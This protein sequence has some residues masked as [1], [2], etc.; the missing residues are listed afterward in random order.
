MTVGADGSQVDSCRKDRV[1][2]L[3]FFLI[4]GSSVWQL[5]HRIVFTYKVML[6]FYS[7][8]T[9]FH[10]AQF[11][12]DILHGLTRTP[13]LW[14]ELNERNNFCNCVTYENI[15][16]CRFVCIC[17]FCVFAWRGLRFVILA[18]LILWSGVCAFFVIANFMSLTPVILHLYT[19]WIA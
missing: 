5:Q 10:W 7:L 18:L 19:I 1:E 17:T 6:W 15:M 16:T 11:S 8:A 2:P 4:A 12:Y 3:F 14:F 9:F 13:V